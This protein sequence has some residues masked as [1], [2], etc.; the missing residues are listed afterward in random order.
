[1]KRKEGELSRISNGPPGTEKT[2][3]QTHQWWVSLRTLKKSFVPSSPSV[4]TS[5]QP[6]IFQKWIFNCPRSTNRAAM[7]SCSVMH[8]NGAPL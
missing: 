5:R 8:A 7:R 6:R 4:A 1:M 3:T 2:K